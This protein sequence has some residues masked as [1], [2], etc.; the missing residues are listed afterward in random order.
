MARIVALA[1]LFVLA[2]CMPQSRP[3]TVGR[4]DVQVE[5]KKQKALVLRE[6]YEMLSR[7]LGVAWNL[8]LHNAPLCGENLAYG[9]G[10]SLATRDD[11]P[12]DLRDGCLGA[13]LHVR[14]RV[15]YVAAGGP[16]DQAGIRVGDM[17]Y[18]VN[19][20]EAGTRKASRDAL[21]R[22][23]AKGQRV[24]LA[25]KRDGKISEHLLTPVRICGFPV[26]LQFTSELNAYADGKQIIMTSAMVKFTRTDNEMAE[27][28]AHEL[29]HNTQGHIKAKQVN[30]TIGGLLI[31]LPAALFGV[32]SNVGQNIGGLAFSQDFET[33]ADYVGLYYAAR[34]GY[35]IQD[36]ADIWRRV[37]S[38]SPKGITT[39]TT[40]PSSAQRF[41][42]LEAARDEIYAKQKAG[43]PLVPEM[44]K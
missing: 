35:D 30:Q 24:S 17:L 1:L 41:V 22:A 37:A 43:K 32:R 42:A 36:V 13:D 8:R 10:M 39:G 31:D 28:M 29:A 5:E 27:I 33:E 38:E 7:V 40:H 6:R 9:L 2:G 20:M 26:V 12:E 34:A 19:G 15:F 18:A 3:P 21:E 11:A 16:A 25:V 4:A 44:K 14:P 23:Y